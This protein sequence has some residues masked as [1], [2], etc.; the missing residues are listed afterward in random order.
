VGQFERFGVIKGTEEV[1]K[2]NRLSGE[3]RFG[4]D[5][6]GGIQPGLGFQHVLYFRLQVFGLIH[7]WGKISK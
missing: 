7:A 4:F 5:G 6:R 1:Y 3:G 2:L